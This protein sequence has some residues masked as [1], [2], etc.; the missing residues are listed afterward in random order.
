MTNLNGVVWGA[1]ATFDGTTVC[2]ST[3]VGQAFRT[4]PITMTLWL[5]ASSRSDETASSSSLLPFPPNAFSGDAPALGGFGVG[6]NV[7]TDGTPGNDMTIE[8]G[9]NASIAFHNFAGFSADTEYFA[10]LAI[11]GTHTADFYVNGKWQTTV[12]ANTPLS[13]TPAPLHLG[14]H[15]DDTAYATKRLFKGRIRDARIYT[16]VLTA[17]E[18][19]QLFA[20]GPV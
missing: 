12:S 7:W 15:N 18:V 10:A 20:N 13:T 1:G 5:K 17:T 11:G 6:L 9:V 19:A 8:T 14:C 3:T 2:G 16:R 4:P